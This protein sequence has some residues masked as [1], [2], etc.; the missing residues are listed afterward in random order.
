MGFGLWNCVP[1]TLSYLA[2]YNLSAAFSISYTVADGTIML[3]IFACTLDARSLSNLVYLFCLYVSA[4][5][6]YMPLWSVDII[7]RERAM[8]LN[9][10]VCKLV[11]CIIG[12]R[13]PAASVFLF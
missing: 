1:G 8:M 9:V 11:P 12:F 3:L 10:A 6:C 2:G 13:M 4:T 5:A 7:C